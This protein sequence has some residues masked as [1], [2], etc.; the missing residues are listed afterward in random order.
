MIPLP[1]LSTS[2]EP[3]A[4]ALNEASQEARVA[5]MRGLGK[6]EL[7]AI[8]KL[9]EGTTL[10]MAHFHGE[11]EKVIIHE[12]KNSLPAFS[13]FQKRFVLRPEGIV[14][15]NHQTMSWVTGPGHFTMFQKDAE[16][17]IDYTR[18]PTTL[19]PEFP[20]LQNNMAGLSRFVYGGTQDFCRRVSSHAII[21]EAR[22]DN[23]PIGAYFML[24][25]CEN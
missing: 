3:I 8:W 22:K 11:A 21:G 23:K 5:W 1:S 24:I 10:E 14:G 12:G 15:Y 16:V 7:V 9:A 2:L 13:F 18:I 20:P 17:V 25:K 4:S 19:H 6:K